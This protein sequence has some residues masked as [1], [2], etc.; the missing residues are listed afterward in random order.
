MRPRSGIVRVF[1]PVI[2]LTMLSA[3]VFGQWN[4][5]TGGNPSRC[6]FCPVSGP[7]D[8]TVLWQGGA[9]AVISWQPMTDGGTL[10]TAR[11][12]DISD[13]LHG[14]LIYA[15]RIDDGTLLWSADLPVDFPSTDW[16]NHLSAVR[17]STVY[18]SRAGNTNSSY[19]YAL[20]ITDGSQLWRSQDPVDESSTEGVSFA[21]DGD[22]IVGCF[23]SIMRIDAQ[24][25]TTVWQEPR[26]SPTSGGSEAAV[27]DG[28]VYGWAAGAQGPTIQVFD[29]STGD[30]LYQSQG[31][32]GGYVQQLAPF[33]G[34]DGTVYA[35]RSQNNASTDYLFALED[36]GSALVQ[37][38][39]VELG[40]VPFAS[41]SVGADG[42]V[43]SYGR[44]GSAIRI[45]P[46]TG[47]V[48][49]TSMDVK[50]GI[51]TRMAADGQGR[52]FVASDG[53]LYSFDEDLSLRWSDAISGVDGPALAEDG[54]MVVCGTGTEVRVYSAGSTGIGERGAGVESASAGLSLRANPVRDAAVFSV[55]APAAGNSTL[56][57]YTAEGRL[58]E[59]LEAGQVASGAD[60]HLDV[61]GFPPGVYMAELEAGGAVTGPVRFVVLGR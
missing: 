20:S 16:R 43:Y 5:G 12:F 4:V 15:Y 41:F 13:V 18:A 52:L 56:R 28:R 25:G 37:K 38:W 55:T 47:Q 27:H 57:V 42:S 1:L 2:A 33:V 35:P 54:S 58:V 50:A 19:M 48:L 39:Q 59:S 10:V 11:C 51:G 34:P 44:D 36:T 32:G 23:N 6:G 26:N 22:L 60:I 21:P 7:E 9:G 3:P 14:T 53:V 61:S 29:L 17:D 49:D 31:L 30:F 46:S 45:D 8:G 24:D 40:Y